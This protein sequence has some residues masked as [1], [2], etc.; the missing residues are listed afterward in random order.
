M[1]EE[2]LEAIEEMAVHGL[3]ELRALP[4][5]ETETTQL[6]AVIVE[7]LFPNG[8]PETLAEVSPTQLMFAGVHSPITSC[9]AFASL[10]LLA[11]PVPGLVT[12]SA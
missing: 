12:S 8:V 1:F 11:D 3:A 5:V 7:E 9:A 2:S 10:K 6:I 4:A